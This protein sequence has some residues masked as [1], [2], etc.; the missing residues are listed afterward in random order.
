MKSNEGEGRK[1]KNKRASDIIKVNSEV[2]IFTSGLFASNLLAL[3]GNVTSSAVGRQSSDDS[4]TT[5]GTV[6]VWLSLDQPLKLRFHG[7]R[8]P[9]LHGGIILFFASSRKRSAFSR[10]SLTGRLTLPPPALPPR[11]PPLFRPIAA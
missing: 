6:Q 11:P 5:L 10:P 4:G 1:K 2:L 3:D 8:T 7:T 9:F